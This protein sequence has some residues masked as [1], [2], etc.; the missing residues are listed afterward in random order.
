MKKF[1]KTIL[2]NGT[3]E[4]RNEK[5]KYHNLNKNGGNKM[6]YD[7][8]KFSKTKEYV[9]LPEEY[10]LGSDKNYIVFGEICSEFEEG[11]IRTK[12]SYDFSTIYAKKVFCKG[13]SSTNVMYGED[14]VFLFSSGAVYIHSLKKN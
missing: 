8:M 1:F 10:W 11:S 7:G 14:K 2:K 13:H 3:I 9:T 4:Y 6:I 5:G 12:W